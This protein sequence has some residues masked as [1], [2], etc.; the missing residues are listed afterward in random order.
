MLDFERL[1]CALE[2]RYRRRALWVAAIVGSILNLINQGDA[3]VYGGDL[4]FAK[5][6]LTYMVPFC[7]ATYGAY[8]ALEPRD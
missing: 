2:P 1:R 8:G 6:M 5:M 7:V 4:N 3:L